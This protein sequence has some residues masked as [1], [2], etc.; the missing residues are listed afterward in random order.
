MPGS[1]DDYLNDPETTE[2]EKA[3]IA[4]CREGAPCELGG[5]K[6]PAEGATEPSVRAALIRLLA[7]EVTSLHEQGVFLMGAL[8]IGQLDLSFARCRGELFLGNCRF[9]EEPQMVQTELAQLSLVGSHLPGL[10]ARGAKIAGNMFLRGVTATGTVDV[11]G[12]RIEGQ[13]AGEDATLDGAGGWA[14]NAQRAKVTQGMFLTRVMATGTVDLSGAEI[15]GQLAFDDASLDG[16]EGM[17]LSAQ[18]AIAKRGILLGGLTATGT[19]D[20]NGAQIVGQLDFEL[21]TL[22]GGRGRGIQWSIPSGGGRTPVPKA[23]S[24]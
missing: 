12:A 2:A 7:L 20:L 1:V 18:G 9:A 14:L 24:C 3:L 13:L 10:F 22:E 23:N 8:I 15:G 21:A 19:V 11:N 5:G 16:G 6:L 4:A 17:A